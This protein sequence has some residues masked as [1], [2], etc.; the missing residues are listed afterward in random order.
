MKFNFLLIIWL[1][2]E[3]LSLNNDGIKS[4]VLYVHDLNQII[5]E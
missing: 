3:F 5:K 1:L 2:E 4:K